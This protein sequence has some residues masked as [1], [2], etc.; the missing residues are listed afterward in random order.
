MSV[1]GNHGFTLIELMVTV[2]IAVIV[3]A[4]AVPAFQDV[5]V[6]S[7]INGQS[8]ELL[9]S[10]AEARNAAITRRRTVVFL[11]NAPVAGKWEVRLDSKTGIVLAQHE[12]KAPVALTWPATVV[13]L[14]FQPSGLVEQTDPVPLGAPASWATMICDAGSNNEIGKNVTLTRMG[15]LQAAVHAGPVTCNPL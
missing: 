2:A 1:R 15:R 14:S 5:M 3:T 13:E 9:N 11:P 4:F 10:L 6:R 8:E 12:F 7:R